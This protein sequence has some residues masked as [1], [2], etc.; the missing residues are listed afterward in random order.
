MNFRTILIAGIIGTSAVMAGCAS[1]RTQESAGE[2]ASDAAITT[3]VKAALLAAKDIRSI[4]ISV[5]TFRKTVQL[6][7]FVD[8]P[9]Q[10]AR[11]VSVTRGVEGVESVK[12]DLRIKTN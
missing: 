2:Y 7:G 10:A 8:S 3:K 11:A 12:N 6:S 1:T 5:E 9:T 4:D